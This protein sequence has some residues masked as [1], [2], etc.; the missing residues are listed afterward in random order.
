MWIVRLALRRPYTFVVMAV[1]IA[2]LGTTAI[3][4]MPVDIFPYIDIPVVSIVWSYGGLSAEEMEKRMVTIFERS[5]TT[6]VN[7]IEHMESQAYAGYSVTRVYFQPNAKVEVGLSQ[8][9][10]ISQ[11]LLRIFPPGT[12][13]P[14]IVKYDASSV[15]I[16]QLGLESKTLSEQELFDL[17]QN[18]IRTQLATIQGCAVPL[19]Y[20]SEE[21]TSELQSLRH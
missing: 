11:T 16:L 20:R 9:T 19:P 1:L 5:M 7:D 8:I 13:P 2:I 4:S 3:I 14:N 12:T 6:T 18:F 21:H 10:A 17:G 15:P